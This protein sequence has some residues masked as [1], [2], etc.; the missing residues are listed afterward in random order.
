MPADQFVLAIFLCALLVLL[1]QAV[2]RVGLRHWR[3]RR[4][5]LV[6]MVE[7][8]MQ[9]FVVATEIDTAPLTSDE[10]AV[11]IESWPACPA[12]PTTTAASTS[13]AEAT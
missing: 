13:E 8:P 2:G 3:R 12:V 6:G 9:S 10:K 4:G 11:V 7:V 1:A 5:E